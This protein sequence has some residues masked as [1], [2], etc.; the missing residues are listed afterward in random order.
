M[1]FIFI[2][3]IIHYLCE[4]LNDMPQTFEQMQFSHELQQGQDFE[5]DDNYSHQYKRQPS[6]LDPDSNE[7]EYELDN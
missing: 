6:H 5:D 7:Q 2:Y 4:K 3:R 1:K